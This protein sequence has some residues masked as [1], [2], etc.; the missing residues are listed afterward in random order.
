MRSISGTPASIAADEVATHHFQ[1]KAH[2]Q[3][4]IHPLKL[5]S[6][7]LVPRPHTLRIEDETQ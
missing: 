7:L 5:R 2:P 4:D 3:R 6:F 1:R